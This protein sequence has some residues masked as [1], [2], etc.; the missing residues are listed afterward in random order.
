MNGNLAEWTLDFP[1]NS[2]EVW[3]GLMGQP[4][5]L[6]PVSYV[7][8]PESDK[9]SPH[10]DLN[11]RVVKG[12]DFRASSG[13]KLPNNFDWR[14]MHPEAAESWI[15]FRFV[16]RS[17]GAPIPISVNNGVQFPFCPVY[18]YIDY[19]CDQMSCVP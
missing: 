19:N 6:N 17:A 5:I 15:G 8:K 18:M 10:Y 4:S 2:K 13:E 12:G 14:E 1:I 16:R 11:K 9:Q 3:D 7:G